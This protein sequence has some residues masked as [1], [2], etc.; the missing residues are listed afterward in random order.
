MGVLVNLLLFVDEWGIVWMV[1]VFKISRVSIGI[2]WD[3]IIVV[4]SG[5]G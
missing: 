2:V 4:L 5:C 3:C 1:F